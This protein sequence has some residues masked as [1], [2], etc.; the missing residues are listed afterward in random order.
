MR[1]PKLVRSA[2]VVAAALGCTACATSGTGG[3]TGDPA[4]QGGGD[5]VALAVDNDVVPP[6]SVTVYVVPES[7]GRQRL[8]VV[9]ASASQTFNYRPPSPSMQFYLSGEVVGGSD[10]R[11]DDFNLVDASRVEW[12]VSRRQVQVVR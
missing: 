9:N 7:G 3:D 6:A 11:S 2:V 5:A 12:S 8:G 1:K 4:Q 10:V